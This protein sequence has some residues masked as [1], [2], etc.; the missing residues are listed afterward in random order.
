MKQNPL[1]L[2]QTASLSLLLASAHLGQA[3]TVIVDNFDSGSASTAWDTNANTAVIAGG[4]QSSSN[5]INLNAAP[6]LPG[7]GESFGSATPGGAED[8]V[9]DFY[10]RV[11]ATATTNRQFSLLVSNTSATVNVSAATINL[12]Y[13]NGAF[14]LF[15]GGA[16]NTV[17]ALG[18]VTAGDWFH[19][20]VDGIDYSTA[21]GSYTLRLSDANGTAF[22]RTAS[23]LTNAQN[24]LV[25]TSLAQSFVFNTAFGTN[26]GFSVDNITVT[27]FAPVPEPSAAILGGIA[28]LG[29]A[30][31]RRD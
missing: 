13:Q 1:S 7:L 8:F 19:M 14:A 11:Q 23:G 10:F 15:S 29:L 21:I 24:G 31:R 26:P 2:P 16:F 25:T 3:A 5:A 27:A 6:N 20:Q 28:L 30:R 18:S 12:R 4:A 22:T 9:I 17:A